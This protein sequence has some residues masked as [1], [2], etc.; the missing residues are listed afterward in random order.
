ML[1]VLLRRCGR[2]DET[3]FAELYD[4]TA[5][6][7]YGMV[8]QVMRDRAH[9]EEVTHGVFLEIWL[10]A[11]RFGATKGST[12]PWLLAIAHRR[13]VEQTHSAGPDATRTTVVVAQ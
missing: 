13:S 2:G 12:I 10:T 4:R 11:A 9:A 1:T 7:V 3:A 8:L 5:P 6:R